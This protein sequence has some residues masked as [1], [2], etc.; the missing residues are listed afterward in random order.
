MLSDGSVGVYFNDATKIVLAS[1]NKHVE[2]TVRRKDRKEREE[3]L[4]T[5]EKRKKERRA[6]FKE[7]MV[8]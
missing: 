3:G 1:D 8:A 4:F 7:A 2:Y 6:G 5:V